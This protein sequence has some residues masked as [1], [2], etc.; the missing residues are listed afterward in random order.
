[1]STVE[2]IQHALFRTRAQLRCEPQ[3]DEPVSYGMGRLAGRL[4]A[5][6]VAIQDIEGLL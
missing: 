1:M 6:A 2:D 4:M 5:S 3:H